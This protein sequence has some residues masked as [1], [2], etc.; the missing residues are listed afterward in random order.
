MPDFLG[1]KPWFKHKS[2]SSKITLELQNVISPKKK[3]YLKIASNFVC[4]HQPEYLKEY[5]CLKRK[6]N[7]FENTKAM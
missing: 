3:V 4:T 2:T 6:H 5:C 7:T 1:K